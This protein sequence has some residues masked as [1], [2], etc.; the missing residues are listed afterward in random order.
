[1]LLD[2]SKL[3]GFHL[4]VNLPKSIPEGFGQGCTMIRFLDSNMVI[5][6]AGVFLLFLGLAGCGSTTASQAKSS[7]LGGML[8]T[9]TSVT[10]PVGTPIDVALDESLSSAQNRSG[11]QFEASVESDVVVNGQTVIPRYAR[12]EGR[13]V[14]ARPS[15]RTDGAAQL[16]LALDSV[17]IGGKQ[18]P[19]DTSDQ[20]ENGQNQKMRNVVL[21]GGP[22]GAGAGTA[23]AAFTGKKDIR[24]PAETPLTFRLARPVTVPGKG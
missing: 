19:I 9:R 3:L 22:A 17:E 18:Y 15:G 5:S 11:D 12:A 8:A 2:I 4:G 1:M 23:T 14:E 10:I 13:V 21:T 16:V 24:L 7:L 20:G 6:Y